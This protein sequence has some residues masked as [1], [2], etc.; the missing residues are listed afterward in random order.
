MKRNRSFE[1][2]LA[3]LKQGGVLV[4]PTETSYGLGCDATNKEAT[5]RLM[6]M[7]GRPSEQSL[8]ILVADRAMAALQGA[9]DPVLDAI[10]DRHWPGPL[11]VVLP[12][13]NPALSP[14]CV[15][16]GTVALRVSSHPA[17]TALVQAFG[18]PVVATSA[19][20]H[21]LPSAYVIKDA[22]EQFS[23]Q[24]DQPDFYLD[25]GTLPNVPASMIIECVKGEI[26]V[27]RKGSFKL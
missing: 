7:K 19:N 8:P 16:N 11:T 4:F 17:A 25:G 21:G 13:A 2:A 18:R 23:Q 12:N 15:V 6:H 22:Q 5:A 9:I 24:T 20:V 1:R 26:V 27:H 10:V 3:T 14:D